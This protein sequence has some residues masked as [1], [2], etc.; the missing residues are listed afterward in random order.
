MTVFFIPSV[1]R[2]YVVV[3][4]IRPWLSE[5]SLFIYEYKIFRMYENGVHCFKTYT[6]APTR[7][8]AA[9]H[10][11]NLHISVFVPHPFARF[12]R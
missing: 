4:L 5:M 9:R 8:V 3:M 12:L 1:V 6:S 2:T 10:L 7:R 11:Q